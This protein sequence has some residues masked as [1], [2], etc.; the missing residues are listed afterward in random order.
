MEKKSAAIAPNLQKSQTALT[1]AVLEYV[2]G[3]GVVK[4]FNLGP[5]REIKKAQEALEFNRKSNLDMENLMTPY[6]Q[7]F[8]SLSCRRRASA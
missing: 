2:Q 1:A 6:R 5:T 4:S 7:F 8:R 3:M